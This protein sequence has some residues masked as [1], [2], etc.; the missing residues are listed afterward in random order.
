MMGHSAHQA[1]PSIRQ[2]ALQLLKLLN[3]AKS[4]SL[5]NAAEAPNRSSPAHVS[6]FATSSASLV[7]AD[8]VPSPVGRAIAPPIDKACAVPSS[9]DQLNVSQPVIGW[10]NL[11]QLSALTSK[12]AALK[13]TSCLPA[14]IEG[15]QPAAV[16][17]QAASRVSQ[18][19]RMRKLHAAAPAKA[20]EGSSSGV[21]LST[22][23]P[24]AVQ[25]TLLSMV[26]AKCLS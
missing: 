9:V 4:S 26:I 21:G 12:A 22:T 13:A 25:Q 14:S 15:L 17:K 23:V 10:K 20:R 11:V 24:V 7:H 18:P 2:A 19:A 16:P 5:L 1:L 6:G 8:A 3:Q